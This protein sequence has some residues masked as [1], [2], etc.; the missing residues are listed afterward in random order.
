MFCCLSAVRVLFPELVIYT[1]SSSQIRPLSF[2]VSVVLR[3][4]SLKMHD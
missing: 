1:D 4:S 3:H 2:V